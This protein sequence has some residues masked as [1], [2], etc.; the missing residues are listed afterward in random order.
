SAREMAAAIIFLAPSVVR[1]LVSA[2]GIGGLL[3][4]LFCGSMEDDPK[5]SAIGRIGPT[6]ILCSA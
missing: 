5:Y 4:R 2:N 3:Q 6:K 1:R